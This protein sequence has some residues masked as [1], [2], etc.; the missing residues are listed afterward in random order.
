M[1]PFI[2]MGRWAGVE[3]EGAGGGDRGP[4]EPVWFVRVLLLL[5][6][7]AFAAFVAMELLDVLANL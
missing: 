7:A 2:A 4:E 6:F 1:G 3:R 5:F